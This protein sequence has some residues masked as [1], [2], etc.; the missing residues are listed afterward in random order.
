M[1]WKRKCLLQKQC[2]VDQIYDLWYRCSSFYKPNRDPERPQPPWTKP[3]ITS[4]EQCIRKKGLWKSNLK[5]AEVFYLNDEFFE[6]VVIFNVYSSWVWLIVESQPNFGAVHVASGSQKL[7]LFRRETRH[8]YGLNT[9]GWIYAS[10][11]KKTSKVLHNTS[12]GGN[13]NWRLL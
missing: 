8:R 12:R 7:N 4:N 1:Y 11:E 6:S 5:T 3:F 10:S 13:S 2:P 9:M